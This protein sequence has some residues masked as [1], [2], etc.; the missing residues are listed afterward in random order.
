[1]RRNRG[2]IDSFLE[3]MIQQSLSDGKIF[4]QKFKE[5]RDPDMQISVGESNPRRGTSI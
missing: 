4:E 1:V 5:V 2:G 3:M